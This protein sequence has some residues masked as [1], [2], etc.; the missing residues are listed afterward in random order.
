MPASHDQASSRNLEGQRAFFAGGGTRPLETR[1]SA[2]QRLEE[3]IIDR[4]HAM[5]EALAEDLGKPEIEAFLSEYH[6][7]LEELRL[8]R[9]SLGKWLKPRRT[10]S[11]FYFLPCRSFVVRQPHGAALVMAPW[12]YPVQLSLSPLIAAVAAG[13]TVVLKPSELAPASARFLA[14]LIGQC[15]PPEHVAVVTGGPEVSA[16]LLELAFDFVFFTGS[17]EVGRIVARKAAQRL[18]PCV[19]ELGGKCP[20]VVDRGADIPITA[21]RILAGKLFNAGQTCFA[22]DFV[23]AHDEIR[24]AL[25]RELANLLERLPWEEEMAKIINQHHYQR[26]EKLVKHDDIRK[27]DDDPEARHMAP[28]IQAAAGW[29]HPAMRE[30]IFGPILPVVGFADREQLIKCLRALPSPLALY[31][32][33]RNEEFIRTLMESVPSGSVCINDTMKQATNL[34]LPFG[35]AGESGHGR[36]RG[37]AGFEAF[38]HQRAVTRRYFTRDPF[39]LLPPRDKKARF[40]TKWLR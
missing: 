20:C 13:N 3:A 14:D 28:R 31:C 11:P 26:L 19:L 4:R 23:A 35:G 36:Y 30:E 38:S 24:D 27:G 15:F 17:T 10:G 39:E 34:A 22:P 5:L 18:T 6:F 16:G 32:F 1:T 40:L 8:V 25:I 9:R 7:L 2:L 12:N 37:R 21:R 29:D 33:S